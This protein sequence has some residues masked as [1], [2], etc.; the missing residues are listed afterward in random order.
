MKRPRPIFK[1]AKVHFE[2]PPSRPNPLNHCN[3]LAAETWHP[4]YL[5]NRV[6]LPRDFRSTHLPLLYL[7]I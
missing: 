1:L 7:P 6:R 4:T 2:T 3:L 5:V